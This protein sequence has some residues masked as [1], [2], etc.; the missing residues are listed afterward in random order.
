VPLAPA[1]LLGGAW[2]LL[3]IHLHR[4]PALYAG[5]NYNHIAAHIQSSLTLPAFIGNMFFLQTIAVPTFG[6]N[7]ALWSLA[8]EFWY[9]ILFPLALCAFLQSGRVK[10]RLLYGVLLCAA[11]CLMSNQILALF[12]V[13]LFGV[14]LH[15]LPR[16]PDRSKWRVAC[17]VLYVPLFSG[18][19]TVSRQTHS[20]PGL[21]ALDLG[22]GLATAA[23]FWVWLGA[24]APAHNTVAHRSARTLAG[25][26]YTLYLS[27]MPLLFLL[28]SLAVGDH[29]W[30]PSP[31]TLCLALPI[32]A[33]IILYAWLL[34]SLAEFKTEDVRIYLQRHFAFGA[35]R[36]ASMRPGAAR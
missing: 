28:A 27:H 20:G 18:I 21:I 26:S 34:A 15:F 1:L 30:T 2:D 10:Q 8:N 31:G 25:F 35:N 14:A 13:W 23:L 19:A 12:P 22:L 33:F 29:R 17:G 6:S 16:C 9:Y 11:T 5:A 24:T 7:G 3:G 32:A 36:I 4:A